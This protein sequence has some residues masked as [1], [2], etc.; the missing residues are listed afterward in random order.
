MVPSQQLAVKNHGGSGLMAGMPNVSLYGSTCRIS[1]WN[2]PGSSS[3]FGLLFE[4]SV[5]CKS[6][7]K[8]KKKYL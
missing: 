1:S 5:A 3:L 2:S 7:T 4:V 6:Y 8:I